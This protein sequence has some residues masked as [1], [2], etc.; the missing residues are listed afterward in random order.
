MKKYIWE[1]YGEQHIFIS[2]GQKS[3]DKWTLYLYDE[4]GNVTPMPKYKIVSIDGEPYMSDKDK[5]VLR[6]EVFGMINN[7][8][9]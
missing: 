8:F 2:H 4:F 9:G 1:Q 3:Q 5:K 6:E 7:M